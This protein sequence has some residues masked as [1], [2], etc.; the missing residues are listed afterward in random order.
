MTTAAENER[1]GVLET[2]VAHIKTDV[3]EIKADVKSLIASQQAVA[4]DLAAKKA[5]E[6]TLLRSRTQTGMWMRFF[7]E[8]GMALVAI[9]L[10][11]VTV[12]SH[13]VGDLVGKVPTK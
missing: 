13:V 11:I 1:L 6:E 5:A 2:E 8:R 7:T 4:V 12:I 3:S 9:V 10:S